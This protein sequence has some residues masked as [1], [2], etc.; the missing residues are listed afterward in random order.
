MRESEIENYL[1]RRV[2][3]V[4]GIAFKFS[5]PARRG[6]PD[7]VCLFPGGRLILVEVKAPGKKCTALQLKE[8]ERFRA[9]GQDVRV[10]DSKEGV[11]ALVAEVMK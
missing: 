1:V 10:I 5:S 3:A 7:R 6:V 11:D 2:V 4:D 8:H 9:L